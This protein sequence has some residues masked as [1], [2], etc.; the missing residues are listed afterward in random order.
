MAQMTM[1]Q[2]ITDALRTDK[3]DKKEELK[4]LRIQNKI[5]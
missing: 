3:V 2:A 4:K 5:I 1:I